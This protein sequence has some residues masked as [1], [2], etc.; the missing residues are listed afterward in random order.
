MRRARQRRYDIIVMDLR[1]PIMDGLE[2]TSLIL[3]EE[4][5]CRRPHTP[6]IALT[7]HAMSDVEAECI[8]AGMEGF[9]TKPTKTES[10]AEVLGRWLP[11]APEVPGANQ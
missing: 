4:R 3:T 6:I 5:T 1:M 8:A 9:L 7:A 2:A 11:A 10:L